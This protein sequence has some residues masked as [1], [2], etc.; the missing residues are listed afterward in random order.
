MGWATKN[1]RM[2]NTVNA[3]NTGWKLQK[4]GNYVSKFY[5]CCILSNHARTSTRRYEKVLSTSLINSWSSDECVCVC[6]SI[7]FE[8]ILLR[9]KDKMN[10]ILRM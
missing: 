10:H 8:T 3:L 7:D 6:V 1:D 5:R 9:R 4:T 2:F